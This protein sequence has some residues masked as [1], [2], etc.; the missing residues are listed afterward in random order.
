M[1][2]KD[3]LKIAGR[4]AD[5]LKHLRGCRLLLQRFGEVGGALLLGFEQPHVLD[6]NSGLVGEGFEKS[7]VRLLERSYFGPADQDSTERATFANE[8]HGKDGAVPKPDRIIPP[9]RELA[10]GIEEVGDVKRLQIANGVAH[11]R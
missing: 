2:C 8:R 4:T 10:T 3:R 9:E 6:G 11:H 1:A 5:N 7:N